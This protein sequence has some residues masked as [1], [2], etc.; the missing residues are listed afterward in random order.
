MLGKYDSFR[1][2][3]LH[4]LCTSDWNNGEFGDVQ[5]YGVY[6]WRISNTPEE[7][8]VINTEITSVL[9]DWESYEEANGASQEFRDQLVGH[10]IVSENSQGFVNVREFDT[11][12]AL[13]ARYNAFLEHYIEWSGMCPRH[14]GPW[15]E[16]ETCELCTDEDGNPRPRS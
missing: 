16:D 12:E 14:G 1:D 4:F 3:A 11:K 6:I 7:V 5:D 10:F 15:G 13:D 2:S 8:Q 9:E